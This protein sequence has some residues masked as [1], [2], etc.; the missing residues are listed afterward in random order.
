MERVIAQRQLYRQG[1]DPKNVDLSVSLA[2]KIGDKPKDMNEILFWE[3]DVWELTKLPLEKIHRNN[4][5]IDFGGS[6]EFEIRVAVVGEKTNPTLVLCHDF[7]LA[8]NIQWRSYI[9][10]LSQHFHIVMPD[11]G[12]YG[13]NSR[14]YDE[15]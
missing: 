12:T 9:K 5:K 11:M 4:Y 3:A 8:A 6:P 1:G 15:N 13:A 2:V 10:S 14:L 7:M